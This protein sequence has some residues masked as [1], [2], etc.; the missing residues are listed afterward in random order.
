M[1]TINDAFQNFL[2][3][4]EGS[5]KPDTYLDYEDVISL[6]EEFLD[7][8][9]D[10]YL[11]REDRSLYEARR[12]QENKEYCGT[13]DPEHIGLHEIEDFLDDYLVEIGG[14]KKFIGTASRVL[15]RFF[16]WAHEKEYISQ[17]AFE[18]NTGFLR[19]YKK[20]Y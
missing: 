5:L 6:F 16:E 9:A 13:F 12:K 4:Q 17:E 8:C 11:S 2:S 10:D 20:R 19:K 14:G 1:I 15:N 7:A 18:E 3:E